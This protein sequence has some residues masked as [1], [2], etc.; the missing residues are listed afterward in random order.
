MMKSI[1]KKDFYALSATLLLVSCGNSVAD[2]ESKL[3]QL[4]SKAQALDSLVNQ[5]VN[6]VNSLDSLINM[7]SEKV[8]KLDTMINKSTS[9]FDSLIKR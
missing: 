8:K 3:N 5:E 4:N 7:E 2:I 6:K 1:T 9:K